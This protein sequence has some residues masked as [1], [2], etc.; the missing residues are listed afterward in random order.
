[1]EIK[2]YNV[3]TKPKTIGGLSYKIIP[4][5]AITVFIIFLLL[6]IKSIF[7]KLIAVLTLSLILLLILRTV[8][9]TTKDDIF[10]DI[11]INNIKNRNPR[12]VGF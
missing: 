11:I 7:Y 2:I 6:P 5:Y 12:K 10:F 1:M 4:F 8:T 9:H 3:L